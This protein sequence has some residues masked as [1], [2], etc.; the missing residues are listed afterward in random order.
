VVAAQQV[1]RRPMPFPSPPGHLRIIL[2][3]TAL[4]A[5]VG[6]IYSQIDV[7]E[8]GGRLF[9]ARGAARGMLT[10]A[11]M[12]GALTFFDTFVLTLPFAAPLRSA[13][14]PVHVAVKTCIFLVV[15]LFGLALGESVFPSPLEHGGIERQDV[16]FSLAVAFVFVFLLDVNRLLGQNVLLNFVIGRYYSPRLESRVFLFLDMEGSTGLAERLGPLAF[17]RLVNRFVNDLSEPI[18]AARG[19]IH[20]YV[21]DELIATWKLKQGIVQARCVVACFAAIDRL[22]RAAPDYRR[23]FGVPINLA[24]GSIAVRW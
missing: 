1:E 6:A 20:T 17:H 14:F 15:I 8:H 10:G 19:E 13:P 9:D 11:V 4:A 24:P 21:G 18:V 3:L 22:A 5:A 23:E 16:L 7:L 2:W 12:G